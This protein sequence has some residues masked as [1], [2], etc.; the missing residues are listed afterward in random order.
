MNVTVKSRHCFPRGTRVTRSAGL[1]GLRRQRGMGATNPV[2]DANITSSWSDF[3][4]NML[5]GFASPSQ[6]QQIQMNDALANQQAATNPITGQIN[7]DLLSQ[8]D[9]QSM[10]G[11]APAANVSNLSTGSWLANAWDQTVPGTYT[12]ALGIPGFTPALGTPVAPAANTPI[13]WTSI[14][15]TVALIAG[16]GLAIY[17]IVK[18]L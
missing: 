7:T 18:A 16:G 15:E 4:Y 1:S 10:A 11:A 17:F 8:A 9:A 3:V 6:I 14:L 2:T 12:G 5:T 13:D